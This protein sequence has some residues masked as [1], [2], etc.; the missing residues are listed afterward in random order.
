MPH[1]DWTQ[2]GLVGLMA[3]AIIALLFKVIIWTLEAHKNLLTQFS[4][5]LKMYQK[6]SEEA[7]LAIKRM[8]E[9]IEKHDDKAE[10]RGRYVRQEHE[11]QV[12]NQVATNDALTKVNNS[13]GEVCAGLGRI[14]GFKH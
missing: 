1:F 14:N 8:T 2:F 4:D 10:E 9:S 7:T 5:M 11:N 13:L 3:G 12:K 6:L